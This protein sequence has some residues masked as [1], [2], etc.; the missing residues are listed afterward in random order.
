MTTWAATGHRPNKLGGYDW[1][2]R[3]RALRQLAA[4]HLD[5][6]RPEKIMIG[7]AIG[8]DFAVAEACLDLDIPYLAVVPFLGQ[9]A[10]WPDPSRRKYQTLLAK[11]AEVKVVFP[12]SFEPHKFMGRNLWMMQ[13]V[14]GQVFAL[15]DKHR[16]SGTW[17]AI[18]NASRLKRPIINVWDEFSIW[19]ATHG[20]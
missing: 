7:M 8:W 2:E 5:H 14:T 19:L 10:A 1:P 4:K 6:Y 13:R 12:G 20:G 17:N 11:A 15:W 16:N 3:D 9:E 18:R